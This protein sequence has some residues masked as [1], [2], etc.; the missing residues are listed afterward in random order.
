MAQEF[1]SLDDNVF[2]ELKK[3]QLMQQ[4]R[5]GEHLLQRKLIKLYQLVEVMEEQERTGKLLGEIL[6]EKEYITREMLNDA[7]KWQSQ[8]NDLLKQLE[9]ETREQIVFK[10]AD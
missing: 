9:Q 6:V 3:E 2:A 4:Q 8:A 10:K 1:E 5:I 7:L